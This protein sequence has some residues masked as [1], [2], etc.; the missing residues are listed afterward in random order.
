MM[1]DKRITIKQTKKLIGKKVRIVAFMW[2][3][4]EEI[5]GILAAAGKKVL[6]VKDYGEQ[7]IREH[8]ISIEEV[9]E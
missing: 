1:S 6:L 3:E 7:I 4:D 9:K 8:L 2:S 5:I